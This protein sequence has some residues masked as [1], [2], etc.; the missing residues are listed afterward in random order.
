VLESELTL[1][2][3]V[4]LLGAEELLSL[5]FELLDSSELDE[6][7]DSLDVLL[8]EDEPLSK[9]LDSELSD[10]LLEVEELLSLEEESE[11]LL[12][13]SELKDEDEVLF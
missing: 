13:D 12:D 1:L 8:E 10:K 11:L 9:L 2:L 5:E 6:D 4:E 7:E 3:D